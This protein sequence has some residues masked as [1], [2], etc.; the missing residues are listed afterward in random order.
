VA[1][2]LPALVVAALL[3]SAC[4]R[5][6]Q[7][8]VEVTAGTVSPELRGAKW[9]HLPISYCTVRN[10]QG[11]FMDYRT[12][13]ALTQRA[14]AGWG[15]PTAYDGDCGHGIIEGDGQNEIGWGDLG[16]EPGHLGEAGNTNIRYRST[17]AGGPPDIVEADI[18]IERTPS[19][20]RDT[21]AC[22]Y[23]TLLHEA[24]HLFGVQHLDAGAVMSP[25]IENCLQAL[26][27]AD[28]AAI[29]EL[30]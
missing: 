8:S 22:L 27:P 11:G 7:Q 12:F 28:L 13:V 1:R 19:R 6:E 16:N 29:A 21:E 24:G 10:E 26:T 17:L 15:V 4:V 2:V 20:G 14:M 5:I 30:Y 25:V 3:L 18:T 23:T 9:A